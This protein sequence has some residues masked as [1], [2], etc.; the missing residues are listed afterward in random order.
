MASK[1]TTQAVA[2]LATVYRTLAVDLPLAATRWGLGAGGEK[3][4]TEAAWKAYDAGVRL[5]TTAVDSL[6]RSPL[7]GTV[8]ARALDAF[9]RGQQLSNALTG[10][11]FTGLWQGVGLSTTAE[12]QALRTEIQTLREDIRALGAVQAV[13]RKVKPL[14][15]VEEREEIGQASQHHNGASRP[16]RAAA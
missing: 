16:I 13:R 12:T 11:I 1:Q 6:F 5:A 7:A 8:T 2:D 4:T 14:S 15:P 9:L 3:E 10:V